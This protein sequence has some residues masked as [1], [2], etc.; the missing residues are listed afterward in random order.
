MTTTNPRPPMIAA[1][2][3]ELERGLTPLPT[4]ERED[5]LRELGAH[6]ED[7]LAAGQTPEALLAG[8]G[9]AREV[10][11]ALVS[12]RLVAVDQRRTP[13][14]LTRM[15]ARA[16]GVP[17]L[18]AFFAYVVLMV[19]NTLYVYAELI[20]SSKV[21]VGTVVGLM[22]FNLPAILVTTLPVAA[23]LVGLAGLPKLARVVSTP[24][25]RRMYPRLAAGALLVGLALSGFGFF[26]NDRVVPTTN[27]LTVDLVSQFILNEPTKP[28]ADR[29]PQERTLADMDR[30]L[31]A[32]RAERDAKAAANAPYKEIEAIN[33]RLKLS[34]TDR[35]LKLAIPA[36]ALPLMALG[37]ALGTLLARR[38]AVRIWLHVGIALGTVM[39]IYTALSFARFSDALSGSPVLAAWGPLLL[40]TL[41]AAAIWAYAKITQKGVYADV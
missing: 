37:F 24:T 28:E 39:A 11:D 1:Y 34:E 3:K 31:A 5:V 18:V 19:A 14:G 8:M 40:P 29:S 16:A 27:R 33:Q 17:F 15:V 20:A 38:R 30:H 41:A 13:L 12:E 25:L 6:L 21:G 32:M 2:L 10:A 9:P 23:L 35:H 7:G 36:Y 26:L 22:L 4:D